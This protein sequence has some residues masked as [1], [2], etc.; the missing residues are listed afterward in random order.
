MFSQSRKE[1]RME[2]HFYTSPVFVVPLLW[3]IFLAGILWGSQSWKGDGHISHED[4]G[5]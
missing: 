4:M 5:D 3:V 1:I 2:G